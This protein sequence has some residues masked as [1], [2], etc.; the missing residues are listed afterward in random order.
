MI[1]ILALIC[2]VLGV[3]WV[4]RR[5]TARSAS[6]V[7]IEPSEVERWAEREALRIVAT[8]IDASQATL[9]R[10]FAGQLDQEVARE[11]EAKVAGVDIAY[12]RAAG[13]RA[14]LDVRVEVSFE[15]GHVARAQRRFPA[16]ALPESVRV[17]LAQT[18]ASHV[19]RPWLFPWQ[20]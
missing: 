13:G 15:D 4:V 14:E 3:Y 5:F 8:R 12:E 10:V 20:R 11:V 19:Y 1:E 7:A 2:L 6:A 16:A 17:E 18:G 9:E